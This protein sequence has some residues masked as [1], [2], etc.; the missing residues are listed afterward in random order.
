VLSNGTLTPHHQLF[1]A[2]YV[3]SNGILDLDHEDLLVNAEDVDDSGTTDATTIFGLLQ[4]AYTDNYNGVDHDDWGGTG[5]TSVSYAASDPTKYSVGFARS[6][7][8]S[9]QDANIELIDGHVLGTGTDD[10]HGTLVRAVLVG[11]A[12]MDKTVDFFDIS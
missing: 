6:N 12:N 2:A 5:I 8:Q 11:D 4:E 7:D 10:H 9:A 3:A 1:E